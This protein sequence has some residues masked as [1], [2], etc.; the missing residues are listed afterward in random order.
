MIFK[1]QTETVKKLKIQRG[2]WGADPYV[3]SSRGDPACD[4]FLPILFTMCL[5]YFWQ[6]DLCDYTC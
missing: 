3:R 6:K 4:F 1:K 2:I 5:F